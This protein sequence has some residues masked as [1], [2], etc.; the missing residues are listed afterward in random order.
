MIRYGVIGMGRHGRRYIDHLAAGIPGAQLEAVTRANATLGRKEANA[1]GVRWIED[2]PSL[3]N[4][5]LI[6]AVIICVPCIHHREMTVAALRAGKHVLLEKPL[7]PSWKDGLAI[8]RAAE[9]AR[10][11]SGAQL[12]FAHTLRYSNIVQAIRANRKKIGRLVAV[13][14]DQR[15]EHKPLAWEH[16]LKKSGGGVI[17]QTGVHMFDLVRYLTGDEIANLQCQSSRVLEKE[18]EDRFAILATTA[19]G[20]Q[21]T[22]DGGKYSDGRTGRIEMT[23]TEGILIGDHI[24]NHLTLI[25]GGQRTT[26]DV[27][28]LA[29]TLPLVLRDATRCFKSGK[30]PAIGI[31]DGL[32][33]LAV[34]CAAYE[35][36]KSGR[37]AKPKSV[38][39]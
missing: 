5:P 37:I 6:N 32:A 17:L 33:S 31:R 15:L 18:V 35:S 24:H 25:Q 36:A 3:I 2:W 27:G 9:K 28:P 39:A 10:E 7:A 13:S 23:G 8:A 26:I 20:T 22:M 38:A 29:M 30:A 12:F 1:L 21:V 16:S 19:G 34:A 4:D 14:I 11:T